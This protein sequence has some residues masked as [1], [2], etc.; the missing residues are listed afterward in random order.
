MISVQRL[1]EREGMPSALTVNLTLGNVPGHDDL[2]LS[3]ILATGTREHEPI[4]VGQRVVQADDVTD[5]VAGYSLVVHAGLI[6][7]EKRAGVKGHDA[8]WPV[9]LWRKRRSA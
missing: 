2:F 8:I 6:G 5:L 7:H 3:Q 1:S 4:P 9:D